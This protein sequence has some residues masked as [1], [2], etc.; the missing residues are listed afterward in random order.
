MPMEYIVCSLCI[1][2]FTNMVESEIMEEC[3]AQLVALEEDRF[4]TKFHQQVQKAQEKSWH[5]R[6]IRHKSFKEDEL[7]LLYDN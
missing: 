4:I 6:H 1:M 5:D 7:V 2:A 3:L